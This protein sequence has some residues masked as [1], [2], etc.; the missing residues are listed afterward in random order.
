MTLENQPLGLKT[1]HS[2]FVIFSEIPLFSNVGFHDAGSA[3]PMASETE[4]VNDWEGKVQRIAGQFLP[5]CFLPIE[6]VNL[7]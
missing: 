3:F 5:S 2:S 6:G 4:G 7:I 1:R